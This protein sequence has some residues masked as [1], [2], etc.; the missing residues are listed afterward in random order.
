MIHRLLD[1]ELM[2]QILQRTDTK[3]HRHEYQ[4][5]QRAN[6]TEAQ[7]AAHLELLLYLILLVS[8]FSLFVFYSDPK[9]SLIFYLRS[10]NFV[11]LGVCVLDNAR[12][13]FEC[14]S[15]FQLYRMFFL[16]FLLSILIKRE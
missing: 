11:E 13:T 4:Y 2:L 14:P 10:W 8:H 9:G 16:T 12:G 1:D 15:L 6:A 3:E 5:H 7:P